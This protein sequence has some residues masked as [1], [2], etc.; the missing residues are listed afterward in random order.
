ML[1]VSGAMREL[2]DIS[3]AEMRT[4]AQI[5]AGRS[6][7]VGRLFVHPQHHPRCDRLQHYHGRKTAAVGRKLLQDYSISDGALLIKLA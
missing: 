7:V 6:P 2:H 1:L 5:V 3:D 4:L